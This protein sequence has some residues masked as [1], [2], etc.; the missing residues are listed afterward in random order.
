MKDKR[1]ATRKK[2]MAFAPV[3]DSHQKVLLGYVRNLNLLGIMLVGAKSVEAGTEKVLTIEFPND[4]PE[5][6]S[7]H[8]TIPA[9][10]VWCKQDETLRQL[11]TGFE[12]T[13]VT[14]EHTMIFKAIMARYQF[15][16]DMP[17]Y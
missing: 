13:H 1:K 5:T 12:F 4:L 8:I 7:T 11:D 16:Q 14:A 3:Y 9:R 2:L 10:V 15:R 6:V 17:D